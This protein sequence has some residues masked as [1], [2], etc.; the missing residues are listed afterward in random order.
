MVS[1]ARAGSG[2]ASYRANVA[3]D[4]GDPPGRFSFARREDGTVVISYGS[5]PVT[6]LRGRAAERFMARVDTR[7]EADAHRVMERVAKP[8]PRHT[9]PRR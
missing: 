1:A 7:D 9:R 6:A 4:A 2:R 5:A 3:S 8:V